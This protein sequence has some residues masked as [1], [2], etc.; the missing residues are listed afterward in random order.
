MFDELKEEWITQSYMSYKAILLPSMTKQL[1][2]SGLILD[3]DSLPIRPIP[4]KELF[5]RW[6]ISIN[7]DRLKQGLPIFINQQIVRMCPLWGMI[8]CPLKKIE[9]TK[10]GMFNK[11]TKTFKTIG[12]RPPARTINTKQ[13]KKVTGPHK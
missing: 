11:P 8:K 9:L 10:E 4:F 12:S 5:I 6:L 1:G 13:T 3:L 2:I 7:K